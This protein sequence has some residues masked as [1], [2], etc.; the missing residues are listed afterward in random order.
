ME[1]KIYEEFVDH[2]I[3][4]VTIEHNGYKGGSASK[5]GFVKI[6][7]DNLTSTYMMINGEQ[8]DKIILEIQGDSE[9]DTFAS[10]FKL[11]YDELTKNK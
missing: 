1:R 3:L 6:T 11:I 7:F 8:T 4:G 10:A 9:R 5:G 2:N